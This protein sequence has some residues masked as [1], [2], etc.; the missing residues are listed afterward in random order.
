MI[1]VTGAFH[2]VSELVRMVVVAIVVEVEV[3][4]VAVVVVV[5]VVVDSLKVR[6]CDDGHMPVCS[7]SPFNPPTF[8]SPSP[9]PLLPPYI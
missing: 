8:S 9:L 6:L 1:C 2:L 3:V 5:V 4:V 7:L